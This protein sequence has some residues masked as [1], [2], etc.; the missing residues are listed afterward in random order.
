MGYF[1]FCL[2]SILWITLSLTAMISYL[3][4]AKNL[5]GLNLVVFFLV[6]TIGGPI[7]GIN[8]ILTSL[9]DY[10]LPEGWDDDNDFNQGY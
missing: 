9:L 7:F 1:Q 8:Q 10:I 2:I 6:F 5:K 3:P 4:Y